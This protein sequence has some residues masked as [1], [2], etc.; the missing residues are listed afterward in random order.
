VSNQINWPNLNAVGS[1]YNLNNLGSFGR[2]TGA[3][4]LNQTGS[5]FV[6]AFVGRFEF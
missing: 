5:Q 6:A 2:F 3:G 4:G 1:T